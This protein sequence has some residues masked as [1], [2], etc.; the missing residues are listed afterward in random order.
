[1]TNA[2]VIKNRFRDGRPATARMEA[3]PLTTRIQARIPRTPLVSP[4]A[5]AMSG[6]DV[7]ARLHHRWPMRAGRWSRTAIGRS[8]GAHEKRC[9]VPIGV[10]GLF[11]C[12][13][14]L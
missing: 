12:Q 11:G 3:W 2:M 5:V 6:S 10:N 9:S 8:N 4:V 7:G 14:A 13:L 1:V